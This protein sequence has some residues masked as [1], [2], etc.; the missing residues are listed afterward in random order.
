M[1]YGMK[2]NY[3]DKLEQIS[4]RKSQ[5]QTQPQ[6]AHMKT[7]QNTLEERNATH[8]DFRE[9]A[10]ISQHL[11]KVV[12]TYGVNLTPTHKESLDM[13]MHKIARL[14]NG[15][16]MHVDTWHDIVGYATLAVEDIE[17]SKLDNLRQ[18]NAV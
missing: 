13:I 15:D 17:E 8:G 14:L 5:N 1:S 3:L 9:G 2:D 12:A 10:K 6:E 7:V 4:L 18:D 11:K 16:P